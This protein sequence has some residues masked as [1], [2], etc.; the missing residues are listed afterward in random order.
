[1]DPLQL[2]F[3]A[4]V[5][6]LML[7]LGASVTVQD[8]KQAIRVWKAPLTAVLCQ[9]GVMPLLAYCLALA[10]GVTKP[11]G[12]SML[13]VGCSP[14]GSTSNLFAYYS[15]GDVALSIIATS[16]STLLATAFMP[17]LLLV[18]SGPFTDDAVDIPYTSLILPLAMVLVPVALGM[19]VK[20]RSSIWAKRVEKAASCLGMA[21][22]LAA[23]VGG[24]L[25][26]Q[27]AW[28][29][30]WKLWVAASVLMPV[31]S[32]LGYMVSYGV[33]LP[34]KV[35]RTV[36]LETGLQNS[37]LALA[38]LAFS[39]PDPDTFKAV[40]IFPLLYSLFLLVDGALLTLFFN[41]LA[42]RAEQS[43]CQEEAPGE[44]PSEESP[45]AHKDK[46]LQSVV[47]EV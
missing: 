26:N 36:S 38:V 19:A 46:D 39:F 21:F 1:M 9:F 15:H 35:C 17:L 40:S 31:G 12:I 3:G 7:G 25:S 2:A 34:P 41:S 42:R 16:F 47:A 33:G 28:A 10:L 18:Y 14:G 27:D 5:V 45:K 37:T 22:I 4:I 29:Q 13:V 24:I 6:L 43:K 23:L 11:Q 32:G 44:E 30:S 20:S 8:F